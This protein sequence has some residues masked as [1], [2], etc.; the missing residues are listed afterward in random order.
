LV[1]TLRSYLGRV[2][3]RNSLH[4]CSIGEMAYRRRRL[5]FS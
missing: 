5:P 2:Q 1:S 3:S 4:T